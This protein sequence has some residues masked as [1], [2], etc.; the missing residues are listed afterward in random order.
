MQISPRGEVKNPPADAIE[1]RDVGLIPWSER[2][3]GEE[4]GNP[5]QYIAWR[6]PWTEESGGLQ[7]IVLESRTRLNMHTSPHV[8]A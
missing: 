7:S 4:H 3:P 5:L 8:Y 2:S 6:T 1:A